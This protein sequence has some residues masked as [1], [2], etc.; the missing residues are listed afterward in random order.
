MK[1]INLKHTT[2][3]EIFRYFE[4]VDKKVNKTNLGKDYF[5]TMED[6]YCDNP[7]FIECEREKA[8]FGIMCGQWVLNGNGNLY[9]SNIN[10]IVE[11]IWSIVCKD[12]MHNEQNKSRNI[13][14][15]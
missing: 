5:Y 12:Y 13:C 3:E 2:K 15:C 10:D 1:E 9:F 11:K 6:E 8:W 7:T 14:T 4:E